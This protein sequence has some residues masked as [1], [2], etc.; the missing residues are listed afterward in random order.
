MFSPLVMVKKLA[1]GKIGKVRN[2][3][4]FY[5]TFFYFSQ[6]FCCVSPLPPPCQAKK[7]T[8]LV[9]CLVAFCGYTYW[10]TN[11]YCLSEKKVEWVAYLGN[12]KNYRTRF[13]FLGSDAAWPI[14][15][16]NQQSVGFIFWDFSKKLCRAK[17]GSSSYLETHSYF[18]L[19]EWQP[20]Y[21]LSCHAF[22]LFFT[23]CC[24]SADH[25][26][27]SCSLKGSAYFCLSGR[28]SFRERCRRD[29]NEAALNLM[30]YVFFRQERGYKPEFLIYKTFS[31][32]DSSSTL[33]TESHVSRIYS[34][35]FLRVSL[36]F[37]WFGVSVP[38]VCILRTDVV[39]EVRFLASM[40]RNFHDWPRPSGSLVLA[41][42]HSVSTGVCWYRVT[43]CKS[44]VRSSS[45]ETWGMRK[46]TD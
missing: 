20:C 31:W 41:L 3:S 9:L 37:I 24:S 16:R 10:K 4:W 19:S 22:V 14:E 1:F 36:A 13:V 42:S 17:F 23:S 27:S 30:S 33:L 15:R 39:P 35:L 34:Y 12:L 44:E 32:A 6:H 25:G 18:P 29:D 43:I 11:F 28:L 7:A 45:G 8:T 38:D 21:A 46:L 2:F 40:Y 5:L 26:S